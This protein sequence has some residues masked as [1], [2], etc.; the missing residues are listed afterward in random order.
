[1]PANVATAP[2][3]SPWHWQQQQTAQQPNQ[4]QQQQ[5]QQVVKAVQLLLQLAL[6]ETCAAA[7]AGA[8]SLMLH[9]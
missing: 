1:L 3:A 2:Q 5:R 7:P 4:Q 6:T 9:G 8:L